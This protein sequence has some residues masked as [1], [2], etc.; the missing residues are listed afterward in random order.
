MFWKKVSSFILKNRLQLFSLLI[1]LTVLMGYQVSKIQF[2]YELP[3]ILPENNPDYQLYEAFKAR[4]GEDGNLTVV[5]IE[6]SQLFSVPVFK[7]WYDLNQ[8]LKLLKG[9]KEVISNATIITIVRNDS[10]K[11]MQAKK[12]LTHVPNSQQDLD[13]LQVTI[14]RLPFYQDLL[15]S[16]SKKAHLM[17]VIIEPSELNAPSLIQINQKIKQEVEQFGQKHRIPV[18]FSGLP[19][20]R[21]AFATRVAQEVVLFTALSLCVTALILLLLFRSWR[22]VAISLSVVLIGVI[23][24]MSYMVLLGF[25]ISILTSLIPPLIVVIGVPNAIFLTNKYYE[26]LRLAQIQRNA[27]AV[28]AEKIGETTFWANITTAIGFGVLCITGSKMLL[29]FGIVAALGVLSTYV[30]CLILISILYSYFSPPKTAQLSHTENIFLQK[31]LGKITEWVQFKRRQIYVCVVILVGIS[32]IGFTQIKAIGYVV[33]DIPKEDVLYTD[34]K[35]FEKHFKGVL[36]FEI[37]ID[38]G[39]PGRVLTPQTL[40]KIKILQKEIAKHPE[41]TKPISLVEA[42]KFVYQAYRGGQPKYFV[43]P[44]ALELQKLAQYLDTTQKNFLQTNIFLDKTH[45][46]T[47]ISFQIGDIGTPQISSLYNSLQPK[48]DSIFNIDPNTGTWVDKEE[49]Y[50]AKI[51]GNSVV[52]TKGNEYLLQNLIQSTLLAVVMISVLMIVLFGSW[53][54]ILVA[55]V[56]SLVPLIITAGIM[57]LAGIPLKPSTILIFSIAFGLSTDATIYFLTKYKDEIRNSPHHNSSQRITD[58]IRL[59]GISMLQTALVLFAG[60]ITFTASTFQGTVYL[61]ILV[62]I[63]LLMGVISNLILLPAFLFWIN[64]KKIVL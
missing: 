10:L 40:T 6:T 41:F 16:P 52:F 50:Q 54:M 18:H 45:R 20:I 29:E 21:T 11:R 62:A 4:Y 61:G 42:L 28:A 46:Y 22:V 49:A 34:L 59:T 43:L 23:W 39:R 35:F 63:T 3:K 47:R 31:F 12:L 9:V 57:G 13:S 1:G 32:I 5:G 53:R 7:D 25:Q 14:K 2:S 55:V 38:T 51:T 27:I 33:D 8:R 48:I 56:P 15:I 44:D 24:S 60:F 30:L 37:N 19:Y 26:Q 64:H 17:G 36:P 58:T